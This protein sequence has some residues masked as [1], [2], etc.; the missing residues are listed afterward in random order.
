MAST[1]ALPSSFQ[2][3][4]GSASPLFQF[5]DYAISAAQLDYYISEDEKVAWYIM[6]SDRSRTTVSWEIY[7]KGDGTVDTFT[8]ISRFDS[9]GNAISY[10]GFSDDGSRYMRGWDQDN[11]QD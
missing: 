5:G 11:T 1:M 10:T 3:W 9:A 7:S 8:S 4:L 6:N 2:L